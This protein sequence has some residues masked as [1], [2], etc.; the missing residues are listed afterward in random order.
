[1][2]LR[3]PSHSIGGRMTALG[4][5][6]APASAKTD[7]LANRPWT[8]CRVPLLESFSQPQQPPS[9]SPAKFADVLPESPSMTAHTKY[10]GDTQTSAVKPQHSYDS[11]SVYRSQISKTARGPHGGQRLIASERRWLDE[12]IW[13]S[14][15]TML[16]H[17]SDSGVRYR[18]MQ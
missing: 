6:V 15:N 5:T 4:H 7:D 13:K 10:D 12:H 2:L 3:H 16:T 9:A 8:L 1:M 14:G 17:S 11:Q 18:Q